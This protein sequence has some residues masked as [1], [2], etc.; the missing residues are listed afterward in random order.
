M[1]LIYQQFI[2]LSK[3]YTNTPKIITFEGSDYSGKTTLSK[4]LHKKMEKRF[5]VKY[6]TGVIFPS[7]EISHICE[8]AQKTDHLTCEALYTAAFILDKQQ[9][10]KRRESLSEILLQDRYWQS[11]VAYGRFLNKEKSI[12]YN[13]NMSSLFI[14]TTAVIYLKCSIEEKIK[15][16]KIRGE[17]SIIDSFLLN[18]PEKIK[19]LETEIDHSLNTSK[20][21]LIV[22][23]TNKTVEELGEEIEIKLIK[24]GILK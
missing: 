8:L 7:K 19:T 16:S 6:N 21:V 5:N 1:N 11:V 20:N 24:E 14:P 23:T 12:H 3:M 9:Y 10:K 2:F 18:H 4:Y 22:N 17:K 15:R 13:I